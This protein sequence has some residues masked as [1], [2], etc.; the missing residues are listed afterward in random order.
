MAQMAS[1]GFVTHL[2]WCGRW[3]EAEVRAK[4]PGDLGFADKANGYTL[5]TSVLAV[6]RLELARRLQEP[7][8]KEV[9]RAGNI[10]GH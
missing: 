5:A 10:H 3:T 7:E 2:D 6:F 4:A 8:E 1:A 9:E